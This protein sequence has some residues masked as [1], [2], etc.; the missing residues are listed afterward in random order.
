MTEKDEILE[1][2]NVEDY[3]KIRNKIISINAKEK[4]ELLRGLS[5]VELIIND[6]SSY[7]GIIAKYGDV[8]P[9]KSMMKL[10][11]EKS[12]KLRMEI[13]KVFSK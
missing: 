11:T 9:R 8:S 2:F 12:V 5:E 10:K 3:S 13:E 7:D 6:I 4:E 1:L